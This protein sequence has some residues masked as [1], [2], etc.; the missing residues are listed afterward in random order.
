MIIDSHAHI[1][2]N[3]FKEDRDAAI[4]NAVAQGVHKILM[5]NIDS[6]YIDRMHQVAA[7]Y[8]GVCIPM[9]GLHPCYVTEHYEKELAIVAQHLESRKDYCA[10]GEIGLDYYHDLTFVEQ[11]QKAFVVQ[12]ELALQYKLPIV[13]HSRESTQACIDLVKPFITKGLKGVFHCYSGSLAEAQQII[14]MGFYLGIGGVLTYKKAGLD[15]LIKQLPLAH[16]ILE[17]DAPYLAPVPHRGKRNEP[18]Y[19]A[20]VLNKMA[21][22]LQL[23]ASQIADITT[24]NCEN[25]FILP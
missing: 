11:Q 17:T 14:E 2:S 5:P 7:D 3:Q 6:T 22:V 8:P 24:K 18:A 13:I 10:V 9:M 23:P 20:L 1:Y 16:M 15:E 21:E 4:K 12:M 19:T 25:L